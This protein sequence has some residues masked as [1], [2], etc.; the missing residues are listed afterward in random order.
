MEACD[1]RRLPAAACQYGPL[2]QRGHR[3]SDPAVLRSNHYLCCPG[4]PVSGLPWRPPQHMHWHVYPPLRRGRLHS[5]LDEQHD[6]PDPR[7]VGVRCPQDLLLLPGHHSSRPHRRQRPPPLHR[8]RGV[9]P[10]QGV[11]HDPGALVA[12]VHPPGPAGRLPGLKAG[13]SALPSPHQPDPAP[14]PA[15]EG[16]Q[17]RLLPRWGAAGLREHLHRPL[18][19]HDFHVAGVLLLP[20]WLCP[21]GRP[22]H[23]HHHSPGLRRG[24]LPA[25]L[26]RGLPVVVDLLCP[27][28]LGRSLRGSVRDL[29]PGVHPAQP[30]RALCGGVPLLHGHPE[31]WP[32]PD[33]GHRWLP[34]LLLLCLQDLRIGEE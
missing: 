22:P 6:L 29:L 10:S 1:G 7:E 21:G 19:H 8:H 20:V 5:S 15:A 14:H 11:L 25:A 31:L 3:R 26:H 34:G 24:N 28:W 17:H 12:G 33:H 16:P 4:V 2:R 27:R 18:L 32:V 30:P 13:D 9:H 23:L